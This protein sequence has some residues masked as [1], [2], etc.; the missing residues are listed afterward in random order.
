VYRAEGDT[1]AAINF[2]VKARDLGANLPD[3]YLH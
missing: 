1:A 3:E 2:A